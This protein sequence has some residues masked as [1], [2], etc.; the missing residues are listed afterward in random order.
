MKIDI[1]RLKSGVDQEVQ[2]HEKKTFSKE[3]LNG[4]SI[5][6]LNDVNVE[7][8]ITKNNIDDYI[9]DCIVTGNMVLPCAITLKPVT[10]PFSVSIEGNT[11]ELLEELN[12]N[13]KK[14]ENTI[15]IFPIIWE[16]ILVEIPS[17]VVSEDAE[18]LSLEGNG[19]KLC[20]EEPIEKINPELQKLSDLLNEKRGVD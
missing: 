14:M 4:T 19:W 12:E 7:G 8:I 15:D 13:D 6:E 16:N 2:I 9:L 5:I 3:E 10:Y 18:N 17:R 11:R 20:T 1:T